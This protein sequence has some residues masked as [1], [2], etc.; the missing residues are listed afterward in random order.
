MDASY[1]RQI[2]D[3][4][5]FFLFFIFFAMAAERSRLNLNFLHG[6]GRLGVAAISRLPT[7]AQP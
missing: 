3:F 6:G 4:F 5:Y 2:S 1:A 7:R